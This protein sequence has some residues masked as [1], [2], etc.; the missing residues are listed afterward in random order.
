MFCK[1]C[2]NKIR[3]SAKFCGSCGKPVAVEASPKIAIQPTP[4]LPHPEML[5]RRPEQVASTAE[6]PTGT[7]S[8]EKPHG[9]REQRRKPLL[10]TLGVA[11]VL[12]ISIA[13]L[14][15]KYLKIG[16][17]GSDRPTASAPLASTA[18][19]VATSASSAAKELAHAAADATPHATSSAAGACFD[20][21]K[22]EPHSL[23]G[24]LLAVIFPDR[25]S[26]SD[27]RKGDDPVAGFLLQLETGICVQGGDDNT[28]PSPQFSQVQLYPE[29]FDLKTEAT[30]RSLLGFNVRVGVASVKSQE[31][32]HDHS[33]LVVG[34]GTIGAVDSDLARGVI[35]R[36]LSQQ[37]YSATQDAEAG[38][39]AT[40]VRGF[41]YALGQGNGESASEFIVPE[42]RI[43]GPYAPESIS[44]FYGPLP[45]PV[46]LVELNPQGSSEYL[47]SYTYGTPTRHC[48]SRAIVTTT[49][50]DGLNLI[51]QIHELEGCGVV[52]PRDNLSVADSNRTGSHGPN[53]GEGRV[54]RPIT[55]TPSFTN[56]AARTP[57][58]MDPNHPLKIGEEW[59]PDA[60]RRANEEG[61]CVVQVTLT[62]DGH[63]AAETLQQSSGFPRLDDACLEA[64]HG[65]RLLPATENGKP[66][67][68]TVSLPIN[69]KLTGK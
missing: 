53:N 69:W 46:S 5:S 12:L 39:A 49:Q 11:V 13:A 32:G 51:E 44:R 15:F 25:P 24:R 57:P 31:N 3:E 67:G 33:P 36:T 58:R 48:Q 4:P 8:A 28:G 2:G 9:T 23:E 34:V 40:T 10:L 64:V 30:M 14:S 60:S 54:P 63:V 45:E 20:L 6:S 37:P 29:S 65:Q 62:V 52:S 56:T 66:V 16:L 68:V 59:Y 50:R 35:P 47:V 27:V 19:T 26:F 18:P 55:P 42:K 43:S 17:R 61:R 21:S 7:N 1:H 41:Y 22:R 38:T